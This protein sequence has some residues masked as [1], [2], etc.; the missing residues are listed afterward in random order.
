MGETMNIHAH[1]TRDLKRTFRATLRLHRR[2]LRTVWAVG[3]LCLLAAV[4]V[5]TAGTGARAASATGIYAA[6]AVL[7]T[8]LPVAAIWL[9]LFLNRRAIVEE[10]DVTVT[11]RRITRRTAIETREFGWEMVRR[12]LEHRDFW[13]FVVNRLT[14]VTLYK[15]DLSATQR[16]ELE[17]FLARRP[18]HTAASLGTGAPPPVQ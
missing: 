17:A 12:V 11:D 9:G 5:G 7:F 1:Y 4:L 15:S 6:G 2:M 8:V 18:G 3:V 14:T 10:V 13:I 16:A